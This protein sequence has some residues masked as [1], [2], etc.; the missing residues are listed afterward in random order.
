MTQ[1][2]ISRHEATPDFR[3]LHAVKYGH[4]YNHLLM[5]TE[6]RN[7]VRFR[8]QDWTYGVLVPVKRYRNRRIM[9]P[10]LE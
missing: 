10:L 7:Q 8:T 6:Q 3:H 2:M 9:S 1:Y 4:A 5:Y